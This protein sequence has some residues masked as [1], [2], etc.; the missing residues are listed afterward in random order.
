MA[1]LC[2]KHRVLSFEAD[3]EW[4]MESMFRRGPEWESGLEHILI[5]KAG[6]IW[7]SSFLSNTTSCA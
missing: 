2:A 6:K 1:P 3:C 7:L 4:E 5:I